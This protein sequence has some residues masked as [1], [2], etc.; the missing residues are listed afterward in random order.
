MK[1]VKK[2]IAVLA[3]V[4]AMLTAVP[5]HAEAAFCGSSGGAAAALLNRCGSS[6]GNNCGT[7]PSS[8]LPSWLN[9]LL[10]GCLGNGCRIVAVTPGQ[11]CNTCAGAPAAPAEPAEGPAEPSEPAQPEKPETVIPAETE[12]VLAYERE[13]VELVNEIR[14][15]Y[16]LNA[17]S[18]NVELTQVARAKSQ[19]MHDKGYFAHNSPTYG[20]PFEMMRAF[21]ISYRTAGENIAYGY[22]TPQAVVNGWMNSSGHRANILNSGYT[23]IGVGYVA[24]GNYWT[25]MFIG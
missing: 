25:Q 14:G 8:C 16:G 9:E 1:N 23:Q 5:V 7:L 6:Y 12:G 17:L 20:T 15:Q 4:C 13:V 11:N 24:D 21:G 18:L 2:Y 10:A 19:D 3:L 22:R